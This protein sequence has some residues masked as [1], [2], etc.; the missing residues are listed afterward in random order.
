MEPQPNQNADMKST[1]K[2]HFPQGD[3]ETK[4]V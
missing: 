1:V 3:A 2:T 4:N